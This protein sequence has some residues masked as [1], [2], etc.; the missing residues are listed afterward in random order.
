MIYKALMETNSD[1]FYVKD[2][3]GRLTLVN[4]KGLNDLGDGREDQV[5]GWSDYEL[6]GKEIG[7]RTRQQEDY[8]IKTGNELN[9]VIE[10]K[11]EYS[12][13]SYWSSTTKIPL[14]DPDGNIVGLIGITRNIS[15][16]KF[17]EEQLKT[18][19]THDSLT[20]L[21]NRVGLIECLE[22]MIQ[23]PDQMLAVMEI[24]LD[25]FKLI[26]DTYHHKTGDQFLIWF[27]DLLQTT[28]DGQGIAA[29]VGGDEFIIVLEKMTAIKT[30]IQFGYQLFE[31]FDSMIEERFRSL[32]VG[33]SIGASF[34]PFDSR[35]PY[36]LI[37]LADEAMYQ[38]KRSGK[39]GFDFKD[40]LSLKK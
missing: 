38:V 1:S 2:L 32:G 19:A 36:H 23:T 3:Y 7:D 25:H 40:R 17:R 18:M 10:N 15:D 35:D 16:L 14:R 29:R 22:E 27:A 6:L 26:N 30:A 8:V 31:R 28:V 9:G 37:D 11:D 5:I 4:K 39:G 24:D 12:P 33:M 20:K 13:N 21:Y 34:Y